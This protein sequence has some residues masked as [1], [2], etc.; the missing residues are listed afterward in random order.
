MADIDRSAAEALLARQD[1]FEI[2]KD[3]EQY[4]AAL[5]TFRTVNM[6]GQIARLPVLSALPTAGF[7]SESATDAAGVK[8]TSEVAWQGL[9]LVAEEIA[10]IVPIHE[11]VLEDSQVSIWGEVRPLIAEEFGR[12][13]DGAVFFG[14]NTPG[15]WATALVPG[16]TAAGNL[17]NEGDGADLADDVNLTWAEVEGDGFDVNVQ[18]ASR[19]LRARVRGLRSPDGTP[20][21]LNNY[22]DDQRT[23]SLYGEDLHY[24]SNGAWDNDAATL[25]AGDRT[26]AILGLRSDVQYKVLTEATVGGINLAERDMV[27]IRAKMRVAFQV[28]NPITRSNETAASRYPFAVL[29]PS[30]A[31]A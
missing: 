23:N 10:V 31:P 6:G 14:T 22:R 11:N 3:A 21:Y 25:L 29:D 7:V 20:I 19:R 26:K 16:A 2:I 17:V 24:V 27:A 1:S 12:I 13:L 28:A 5:S 18:Y 30:A 15:T 8:P 9:D 4:S